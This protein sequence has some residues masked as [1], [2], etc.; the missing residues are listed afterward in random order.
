MPFLSSWKTLEDIA[1]DP[2]AE[3]LN[4]LGPAAWRPCQIRLVLCLSR[5]RTGKQP[6][7]S[8]TLY[9]WVTQNYGSH[10]NDRYELP[11]DLSQWFKPDEANE[12][13]YTF[14]G[15]AV[16]VVFTAIGFYFLRWALAPLVDI[17]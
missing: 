7:P 15:V 16:F 13:I 14:I 10:A 17:S 12:A 5:L 1:A 3:K 9:A 4:G 2:T 11:A 6:S 8:G